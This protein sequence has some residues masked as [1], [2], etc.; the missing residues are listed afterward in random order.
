MMLPTI[1]KE[2]SQTLSLQ[3]SLPRLITERNQDGPS[4]CGVC[5]QHEARYTCPRCEIPY[6]SLDC[7]RA[8]DGAISQSG[9][10]SCKESFYQNRA[11]GILDLE[12]KER[13][14]ET[15]RMIQKVYDQNNIHAEENSDHPILQSAV[16]LPQ[17]ELI[18]L[19]KVAEEGTPEELQ[20]VLFSTKPVSSQIHQSLQ[21]A[22]QTGQMQ[23]W[24]VE[25]WHPWWHLELVSG[26]SSHAEGED[27]YEPMSQQTLDERLLQVPPFSR[28][29]PRS[30]QQ[31]PPPD[32]SA[33]LL[34]ILF[35]IV[36]TLR[37]YHGVGNANSGNAME[38]AETLIQQS[39]VLSQDRRWTQVEQLLHDKSCDHAIPHP[40]DSHSILEDVAQVCKNFRYVLRALLEAHDIVSEAITV[41]KSEKSANDGKELR[42][43]F[44]A[45][46]KKLEFYMSWVKE[47]YE[48]H[49]SNAS[50]RILEWLTEWSPPNPANQDE[51]PPSL[52][53]LSINPVVTSTSTRG[54]LIEE[55]P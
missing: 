18:R 53:N 48:S 15:K 32:L 29:L 55:I 16:N 42:K 20:D 41:M 6:C 17:D 36:L 4:E 9:S 52:Q 14:D 43:H 51:T 23:E 22:I 5:H 10:R 8:H 39:L 11:M 30:K 28:L 46:A 45:V 31:S 54:P 38:A 33:N 21:H 47:Y 40:F 12:V 35:S 7:Y 50:E 26:Q 34:D 25:S 19:L 1:R 37:L 3:S 49:L 13:K 24:L 2:H 44:R 27:E